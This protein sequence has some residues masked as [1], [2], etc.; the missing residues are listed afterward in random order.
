[1][2]WETDDG[3]WSHTRCKRRK[4]RRVGRANY[5]QFFRFSAGVAICTL[6]LVGWSA[7]SNS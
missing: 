5:G 7:P 3:R 1:M 4:K 6:Y 2:G